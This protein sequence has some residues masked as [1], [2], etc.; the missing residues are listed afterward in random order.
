MA[1]GSRKK[2]T[3][4]RS[5]K[6][7]G[8]KAL[9]DLVALVK[10]A[11]APDQPLVPVAQSVEE[12]YQE[13]LREKEATGVEFT[14]EQRAWLDAIKDHIANALSI[15]QEALQEVPFNQMGGLGRAYQLFGDELSPMMEELNERLAA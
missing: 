9:V 12:R 11:I 8:G 5:R 7:K 2:E 14:E 1:T 10:H 3:T 6:G 4:T 15:D 13:W